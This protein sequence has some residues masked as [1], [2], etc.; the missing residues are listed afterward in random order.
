MGE[1]AK[2]KA[3]RKARLDQVGDIV[4]DHETWMNEGGAMKLEPL[5]EAEFVHALANNELPEPPKIKPLRKTPPVKPTKKK[6]PGP[7]K[8]K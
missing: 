5:D 4:S 1:T 6:A 3:L 8:K 2:E 7:A